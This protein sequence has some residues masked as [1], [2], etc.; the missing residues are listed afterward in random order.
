MDMEIVPFESIG[1]LRFGESRDTVRRRL[2]GGYH[3]FNKDVG[4]NET[5]AYDDL[6]L[7]L[8]F[9]HGDRLEFV[10]AFFPASPS[11]GGIELLGRPMDDVASDLFARGHKPFPDDVG[12]QFESAGVGLIGREG[13]VEGV[14]IFRR[15][16]YGEDS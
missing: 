11:L 14:A 15:G 4:E 5:D 2:G 6:G 12:F 7:H 10:E 13:V 1:E 9:G 3:S 8:Y 16:Y